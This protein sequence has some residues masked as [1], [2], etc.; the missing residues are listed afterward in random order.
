[1]LQRRELR[2]GK[3]GVILKHTL[4]N[5]FAKPLMTLF[6]VVSITI[7]SFA[8]MMAFD[9]SNSLENIFIGLFSQ[10]TGTANVLINSSDDIDES[11]FEGISGFEAAYVS[12]K[13][14]NITVRND[15]MY[16]YY[17]QKTL[18]ISGVD[19]EIASK[20]RI[21]P[22][23]IVLNA[24]EII[25]SEVM[26]KELGLNEGDTLKVFGDNYIDAE[27]VIKKIAKPSGLLD[28]EYSAVV[29]DEG[30]GKLCYNGHPKHETVY[31]R[32]EDN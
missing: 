3:M 30:M 5:I 16:A 31:I 19:T 8:G 1:M 20:M 22:K 13:T 2:G 6:L 11:D 25:I 26:A 9:M 14:S 32:V 18:N 29:S 15:Q 4:R 23:D 21:I 27:Y 24:D 28:G 17:N 10:M 12:S 7:C